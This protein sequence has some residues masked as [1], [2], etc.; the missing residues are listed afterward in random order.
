MKQVHRIEN[1]WKKLLDSTNVKTETNKAN[2]LVFG[3]PKSGKKAIIKSILDLLNQNNDISGVSEALMLNDQKTRFE[4]VYLL[5]YNYAKINEFLEEDSGEL[6]KLNF[7]LL[8]S[9][10]EHFHKFL[11]ESILRNM[12]IA[13]VVDLENP[14]SLTEN[15]IEWINFVSNNLM[16]YL[17]ELAPETREILNEN[18]ESN[19]I[20][21]KFLFTGGEEE[22]L[23]YEESPDITFS[24][25][26][27]LLIIANKADTLDNLSEQK[28]LDYVQYKLR[29]LAVT[30]G[31]SLIYTSTKLNQNIDTLLNYLSFS[32]LDNKN[33]DLKVNLTNEKLFIPFGFDQL[34]MLNEDFKD[35]QD[36]LFD[37]MPQS[38]N[39]ETNVDKEDKEDIVNI[40]EFLEN[41]RNGKF[42]YTD[43]KKS[44]INESDSMKKTSVFKT[45]KIIELLDGRKK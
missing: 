24:L 32:M 44:K 6:G 11:D 35:C 19:A 30:Y 1:L 42:N 9:K 26:I 21:N 12:M 36:F 41:L 14:E 2:V 27:P 29:S 28:A 18:F 8:N 10:Y 31:A 33:S 22:K 45:R 4:K 37:R 5:D 17:S 40:E 16:N 3:S 25:R 15:F 38:F 23:V 13:I 20:K 34:D 39:E 43:T 7:H